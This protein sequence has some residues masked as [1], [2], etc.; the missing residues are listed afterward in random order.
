MKEKKHNKLKAALIILLI[1][2]TLVTLTG[3]TITRLGE[4][5]DFSK[6]DGWRQTD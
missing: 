3:C 6:I 4:P 5:I 2:T 1:A